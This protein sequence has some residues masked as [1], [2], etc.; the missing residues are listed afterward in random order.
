MKRFMNEL[1]DIPLKEALPMIQEGIMNH[2]RYFGIQTLKCP[3]DA[4]VYQ[5]LIFEVKPGVIIEIGNA[6]G[7]S[8][9]FLAHQC[10]LLNHGMVIGIDITQENIHPAARAHP[11]IKFIQGD[12]C[13]FFI[14][15][16]KLIQ[17]NETVMV[18][19]D[20]SHTFHNTLS[21]L[22]LYSGLIKSGGYIIIEDS[23]CHHG[24]ALGPDPGPFEAI[25]AFLQENS[26]FES[27]RAREHFFIT[28]NPKGFLKRK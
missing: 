3:L 6:F 10:D 4:W 12:A 28:W 18:I 26:T 24:L 1:L 19:D 14:E 9:L 2:T 22:R 13:E 5:E 23:I 8:T 7:G 15:V 20:S 16:K 21:I 17:P 25:E 11:R 27:D